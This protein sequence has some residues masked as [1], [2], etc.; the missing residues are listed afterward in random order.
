VDALRL[1]ALLRSDGPAKRGEDVFYY[2]LKL[3]ANNTMTLRRYHAF[4]APG[5]K[6]EQVAFTL[7]HDAIAKVVNDMTA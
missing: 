5:N 2:E 7:T 1:E 3:Q 4:T 6:R